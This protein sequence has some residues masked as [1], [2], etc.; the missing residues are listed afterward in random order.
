MDILLH[1]LQE[2][3]QIGWLNALRGFFSLKW[4]LLAST[5]M[6]NPNAPA[7]QQE[8]RRRIGTIIHRIQ[9]FVR[10]KWDGRNSALHRSD[11]YEAEKCRTLEEA[12]IR[13]YHTQPHLLPVGEQ[14]ANNITAKGHF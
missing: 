14:Q 9:A 6:T 8:G 10:A 2:Q 7:Q 5:H 11:Q 3:H 4:Q 13:H 1:A 12:E